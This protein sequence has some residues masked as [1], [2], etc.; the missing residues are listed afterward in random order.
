MALIL[1]IDPGSR[2]TGFGI[3][4]VLGS[5]TEYITSG[6]IRIP[7]LLAL[8]E[9]LKVIFESVTEIIERYS[10]QEMAIE[11][12]F[13]AKNASSALKLGQA[14]GAAI[15]AAVAQN[16]PVS[17]YEARKVKQSIVGSGAADKLQVQHMVKTLLH[18]PAAP[19]EDAA[20]A[21]AVALCHA[22]SQQHLIK[23]AGAR[24][25]RRGRVV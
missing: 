6:V 18:L 16:L 22:N 23:L 24:G 17:E 3:I 13:M 20:D 4:N 25:F 15:V 10:P 14:R 11:Q 12:V 2:K 8:P 9:R 19:Q 5:K 1:G 7:E 21:L